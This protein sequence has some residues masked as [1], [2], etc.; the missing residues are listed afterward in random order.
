MNVCLFLKTFMFFFIDKKNV[1][2]NDKRTVSFAKILNVAEKT[3]NVLQSVEIDGKY[4]EFPFCT[5]DKRSS[6][7]HRCTYI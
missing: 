5:I 1:E 6:T 7:A 4:L 2:R 3:C